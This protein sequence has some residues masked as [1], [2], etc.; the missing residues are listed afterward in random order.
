MNFELLE[1]RANDGDVSAIRQLVECYEN[2]I[3]VE[4]DL[5]MAK[6]WEK[7]LPDV[8]EN[9]DEGATSSDRSGDNAPEATKS[10]DDHHQNVTEKEMGHHDRVQSTSPTEHSWEEIR[11]ELEKMSF[12]TLDQ[13]VARGNYLA[14]LIAGERY[15]KSQAYEEQING[16]ERIR[17]AIE[18]IKNGEV[19]AASMDAIKDALSEGWMQL[20]NYY[21]SGYKYRPGFAEKA[22]EACS[23]AFEIDHSNVEGLITCYK[24]G[25]GCN[26]DES[27]ISTY[28]RYK[29]ES[30]GIV[31]KYNYAKSLGNGSIAAIEF[32]QKALEANDADEH[33]YYQSLARQSL[34]ELGEKEIDGEILDVE[35]EKQIQRD[36]LKADTDPD[37]RDINKKIAEENERQQR[38]EEE[39]R[40]KEE[41]QRRA[42]KE[43]AE[44][45]IHEKTQKASKTI[46]TGLVVLTLVCAFAFFANLTNAVNQ[47]HKVNELEKRKVEL[48]QGRDSSYLKLRKQ[49]LAATSDDKAYDSSNVGSIMKDK[50]D[51]IK[52]FDNVCRGKIELSD[53]EEIV[54][55][56]FYVNSTEY[57]NPNFNELIGVYKVE[58]TYSSSSSGYSYYIF[59]FIP[60]DSNVKAS[61]VSDSTVFGEDA[62]YDDDGGL[63]DDTLHDLVKTQGGTPVQIPN[64]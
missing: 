33:P 47:K 11:H 53:N 14:E 59:T 12:V 50:S 51:V 15:L 60:F 27:K 37:A 40:R 9:Y 48:Q 29:A 55:S 42:K 49:E 6:Q 30:G 3:G 26:R 8:G 21:L 58:Q 38:A 5:E 34:A 25:I 43:A 56:R 61:S 20:A 45:A 32:F 17:E 63:M 1:E 54:E 31:E 52:Q 62:G 7:M 4:Q 44:R 18:H 22:F 41:E 36:I 10:H 19:K 57:K 39:Q 2:G 35:K 13:V 28:E 24:F 16:A 46:L 64:A 23:N